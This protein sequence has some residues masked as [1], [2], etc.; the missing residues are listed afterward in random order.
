MNLMELKVDLFCPL[1]MLAYKIVFF[2]KFIV[3]VY[4][5]TI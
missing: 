5:I 2:I 3:I 4:E 1:L